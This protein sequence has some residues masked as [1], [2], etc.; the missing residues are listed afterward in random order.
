LDHNLFGPMLESIDHINIVV[1]DLEAMV[2]FYRDILGLTITKRVTIRGECIDRVVGLPG[3]EAEV[4]YLE[5]PT[6]PRIELLRYLSPTGAD[7][8]GLGLSNTRGLRHLALRVEQIETFA[9]KLRD[10]GVELLSDVQLVPDSQVSYAGGVSKRL[11]Y[12][13]DPE[14]NLL[15]L[16]SYR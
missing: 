1:H 4:V 3:V 13:R 15:E 2:R 12:F 5:L 10:A 8:P 16:C 9:S 7:P 14:G 6:G 11:V